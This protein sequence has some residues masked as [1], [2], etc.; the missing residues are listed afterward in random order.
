MYIYIDIK[1]EMLEYNKREGGGVEGEIWEEG[2]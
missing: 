1:R 2:E